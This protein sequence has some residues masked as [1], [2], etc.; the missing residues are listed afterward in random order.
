MWAC[1]VGPAGIGMDE[2]EPW[3]ELCLYA[4]YTI[5]EGWHF[6][7]SPDMNGTIFYIVPKFV[8]GFYHKIIKITS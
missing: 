1:D 7:L 3:R 4:T 6:D 2:T 8:K 5:F